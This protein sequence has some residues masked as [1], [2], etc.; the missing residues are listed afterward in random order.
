MGCG[1]S[2]YSVFNFLPIIGIIAIIVFVSYERKKYG[3]AFKKF[4]SCLPGYVPKISFYPSYKGDYKGL[5]FTVELVP[6]SKNTPSYLHIYLFKEHPFKLRISKESFLTGLGKKLGLLREIKVGDEPFDN[7]FML[8]TD[9]SDRAKS[10]LYNQA[11]KNNIRE[12][13]W[14][15]FNSVSINY[16]RIL[17]SKPNYNLETDLEPGK[18]MEIMGILSAF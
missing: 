15:G 9:N 6:Q 12:L 10:Y 11:L 17:I 1:S 18:V 7:E 16:R 8:T 14:R 3:D 2:L 4:S 5:K 13:F